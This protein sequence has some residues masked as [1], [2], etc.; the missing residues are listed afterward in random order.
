MISSDDHVVEPRTVFVDRVPSVMKEEAPYVVDNEEGD[1]YWLVDGEERSFIGGESAAGRECDNGD[2]AW[3]PIRYDEMRP[4]SY[5]PAARVRDMDIDGVY[6]SLV[7]P[8]MVWGFLWSTCL[9]SK[10][11]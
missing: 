9:G 1:E 10:G 11:S 5:D 4:G 2:D 7:F 6:A 3:L 8:S